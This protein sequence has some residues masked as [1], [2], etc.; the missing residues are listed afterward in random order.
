MSFSKQLENHIGAIWLFIHDYNRRIRK[1]L[2]EQGNPII[3]SVL[4]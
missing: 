1:K 4:S 2:A 3:S